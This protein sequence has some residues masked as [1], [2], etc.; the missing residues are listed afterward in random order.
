M[1]RAALACRA[2]SSDN[3]RRARELAW[4]WVAS[5]WPRLVPGPAEQDRTSLERQLP[6]QHLS[7]HTNASGSEWLLQ[8]S[9]IEKG[10][11]RTW[12]TRVAILDAGDCDRVAVETACTDSPMPPPVVAPP[13]LL[14]DWVER[15]ALQDGGIDV[16]PSAREVG[17]ADA[18]EAFCDHVLLPE[19]RLPVIALTSKGDS[20]YFGVDPRA[21]AEA[22]RGLAHVACLTPTWAQAA[23]DRFGARLAPLPGVP[24]IYAPG[25]MPEDEP[26]MHPHMRL[27]PRTDSDAPGSD[28]AAMKRLLSRRICAMS[29]A[30]A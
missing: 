4:R 3:R 8:L 5:K 1:V 10:G 29:V 20:R 6:G 24:R 17:D 23:G 25:F 26:R 27:A 2:H 9:H 11:S 14:G 15:L 30:A 13:K 22:V 28:T 21:L 19:R 7:M 18:L 12:T 16:R